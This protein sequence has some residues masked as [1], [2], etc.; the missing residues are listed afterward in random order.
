MTLRSLT[1]HRFLLLLSLLFALGIA[2][3]Q[4]P[5]MADRDSRE[6]THRKKEKKKKA[7]TNAELLAAITQKEVAKAARVDAAQIRRGD[8]YFR[9]KASVSFRGKNGALAALQMVEEQ[10]GGNL[11]NLFSWFLKKTRTYVVKIKS[12]SLNQVEIAEIPLV[13]LTYNNGQCYVKVGPEQV[14][15]Y[16]LPQDPILH[17]RVTNEWAEGTEFTFFQKIIGLMDNVATIVGVKGP[18]TLLEAPVQN[19]MSETAKFVDDKLKENSGVEYPLTVD[20]TKGAMIIPLHR[21]KPSKDEDYLPLVVT[22]VPERQESFLVEASGALLERDLIMATQLQQKDAAGKLAGSKS[23]REA[24]A[25]QAAWDGLLKANDPNA[26]YQQCNAL[27]GWLSD[28]VRL[29][30]TDR[31]VLQHLIMNDPT[32]TL[33]MDPAKSG[34]LI[35]L[36]EQ[37]GSNGCLDGRLAS[38][39]DALGL[40]AQFDQQRELKKKLREEES[41]KLR[42]KRLNQANDVLDDLAGAWLETDAKTRPERVKRVLDKK[43]IAAPDLYDPQGVAPGDQSSRVKMIEALGGIALS[44]LGCT[45]VD[46]ETAISDVVR[47][48]K[49]ADGRLLQISFTFEFPDGATSHPALI[50]DLVLRKLDPASEDSRVSVTNVFARDQISPSCAEKKGDFVAFLPSS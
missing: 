14:T 44:Y 30:L 8:F 4:N 5:V 37:R 6:Q 3:V 2:S 25:A 47:L 1:L 15:P 39:M 21:F 7:P 28:S 33:M 16:F 19:A 38:R 45:Y 12:E 9:L 22:L 48:A 17:V 18:L 10:C 13:A 23:L 32:G 35:A 31:A 36:A 50:K 20:L 26:W 41:A 11:S 29:S 27:H 43:F 40:R 24:L 49:M 42:K 34:A 46:G